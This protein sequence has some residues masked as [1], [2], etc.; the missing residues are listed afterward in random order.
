M[1]AFEVTETLIF[2]NLILKSVISW[3]GEETYARMEKKNPQGVLQR[4]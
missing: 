3:V 4:H 1:N 2:D